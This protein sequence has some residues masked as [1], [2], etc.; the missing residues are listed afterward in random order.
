MNDGLSLAEIA[1]REGLSERGMRKYVRAL[2]ARRGLEATDEFIAVQVNRLNE[3]LRKSYGAMSDKD[4]ATVDRVV[5]IVRELGRYHGF[6][7][8]ARGT[9][10]RHKPL[11]RL[12]SGAGMASVRSSTRAAPARARAQALAEGDRGE[13]AA[14]EAAVIPNWEFLAELSSKSEEDGTEGRR[15]LLKNLDSRA[16]M[17]RVASLFAEEVP[18]EGPGAEADVIPDWAEVLA[19]L[20]T[21][22]ESGGGGDRMA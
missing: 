3:A 13:D 21:P 8:G 17:A 6:G 14:A 12:D 20:L 11:G 22:A 19:R 2:I 18:G 1:A 5:R 7:G 9:E 4:L 10:R 16:E 15:N